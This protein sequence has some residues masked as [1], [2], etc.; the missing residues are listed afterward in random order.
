MWGP[1]DISTLTIS[2]GRLDGPKVYTDPVPVKGSSNYV[3][4]SSPQNAQDLSRALT[5]YYGE[6]IC[7][8]T[9]GGIVARSNLM[10]GILLALLTVL[11]VVSMVCAT[12]YQKLM[13]LGWREI[14]RGTFGPPLIALVCWVVI[15]GIRAL[16]HIGPPLGKL[17][18]DPNLVAFVALTL[19]GVSICEVVVALK[20]VPKPCT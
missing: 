18:T 17:P 15:G 11:T 2:A 13:G 6:P 8:T 14:A 7:P 12:K 3:V 19:I 4:I 20:R 10:A 5:Y 16:Y 1:R 9:R